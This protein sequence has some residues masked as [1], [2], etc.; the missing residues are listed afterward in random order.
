MIGFEDDKH[1][2]MNQLSIFLGAQDDMRSIPL[3]GEVYIGVTTKRR[4]KLMA[5]LLPFAELGVG[6]FKQHTH[7]QAAKLFGKSRFVLCPVFGR[8]GL[9][10]L[11]GLQVSEKAV[12]VWP[13]SQVHSAAMF[14]HRA[15]DRLRPAA[16]P[17]YR[18]EPG[19]VPVILTDACFRAGVEQGLGVVLYGALCG[20]VAGTHTHP[21]LTG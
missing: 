19:P 15:V 14:L 16:F 4:H 13:G 21:R 11:R 9:A 10:A 5:L 12:Q 17:M 7:A 2:A 6:E 20:S 8:L 1:V 18:P 3:H